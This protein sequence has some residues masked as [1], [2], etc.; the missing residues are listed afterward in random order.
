MK[1]QQFYIYIYIDPKT[2]EPVYVGKGTAKRAVHHVYAATHLGNL[3]RKRKTEGYTCYPM[4]L[5]MSSEQAAFSAEKFYISAIGR[6]DLGKGTLL[7]L[8]DGGEGCS[9]HTHSDQ[10]KEK[11]K[12]AHLGKSKSSEHKA[13][14]SAA[15]KGKPGVKHTAET[16]EKIAASNKG[17]PKSSEH[18]AKLSAAKQNISDETRAKL[19]DAQ[20]GKTSSPETRAKITAALKIRWENYR[21]QLNSSSKDK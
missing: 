18:K 10:T 6:N 11:M 21:K 5:K 14:I 20:K 7:N 12:A 16:K 15:Q 3:L 4:I 8:T 19:S 2:N 13:K 1:T 17:K 9:G